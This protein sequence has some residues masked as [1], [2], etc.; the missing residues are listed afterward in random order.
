MSVR[1][2]SGGEDVLCFNSL[3]SHPRFHFC[4]SFRFSS[5]KFLIARPAGLLLKPSF[6]V[7]RCPN[8]ENFELE[9]GKYAFSLSS[10]F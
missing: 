8:N 10:L 4:K 2:V 3:G 5:P 6:M 1:F 9:V 7:L